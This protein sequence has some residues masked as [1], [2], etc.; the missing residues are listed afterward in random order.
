[1]KDPTKFIAAFELGI[2]DSKDIQVSNYSVNIDAIVANQ[3]VLGPHCSHCLIDGTD[4]GDV[5]FD[6]GLSKQYRLLRVV[7][8]ANRLRRNV[9]Q[10]QIAS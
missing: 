7:S 8:A 6:C 9:G 5:V 10:L 4:K 3:G 2:I 1:M